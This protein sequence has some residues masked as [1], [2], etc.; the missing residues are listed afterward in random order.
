MCGYAAALIFSYRITVQKTVGAAL[1][2]NYA[3]GGIDAGTLF[4][5]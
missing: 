1:A 4:P 2:A 3:S 5:G